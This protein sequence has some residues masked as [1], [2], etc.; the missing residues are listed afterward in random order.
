MNRSPGQLA[1]NVDLSLLP[2]ESLTDFLCQGPIEAVK[3]AMHIL[4]YTVQPGLISIASIP[5]TSGSLL[6]ACPDRF[7]VLRM[8][9]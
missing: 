3:D 4:G 5:S 7:Q 9:I 1:L 2:A 8:L 6:I